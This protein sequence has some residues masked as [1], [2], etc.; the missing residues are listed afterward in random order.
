MM[1]LRSFDKLAIHHVRFLDP[2][3][4][5]ALSP[6]HSAFQVAEIS[7]FHPPAAQAT[8]GLQP[9]HEVD[10]QLES[11]ELD[12]KFHVHRLRFLIFRESSVESLDESKFTLK[13]GLADLHL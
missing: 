5:D 6:K 13:M 7:S 10:E 4:M 11:D 12:L 2:E 9:L 8:C 3:K 1:I